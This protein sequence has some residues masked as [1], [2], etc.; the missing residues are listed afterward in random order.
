MLSDNVVAAV[1]REARSFAAQYREPTPALVA[2]S[3]AVFDG[4]ALGP[5]VTWEELREAQASPTFRAEVEELLTREG[6]V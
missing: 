6:L 5:H 1:R 2:E 4:L 3:M